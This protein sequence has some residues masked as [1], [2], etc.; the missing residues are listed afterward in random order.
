MRYHFFGVF[1]V[2]QT[3]PHTN[4]TGLRKMPDIYPAAFVC[5]EYY[6]I[7]LYLYFPQ[8]TIKAQIYSRYAPGFKASGLHYSNYTY[9][10][11]VFIF[12]AYSGA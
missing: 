5:G 1:V 9:F 10:V 2:Q 8:V 12:F 4:K 3:L 6:G 7:L 11:G